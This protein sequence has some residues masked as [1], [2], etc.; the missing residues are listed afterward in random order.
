M[1]EHSPRHSY[2][3]AL[4]IGERYIFLVV[5]GFLAWR[6]V[7]AFQ[8]TASP[9]PLL[10]LLDQLVVLAFLLVRRRSTEM[11]LRPGDWII[12]FCGTLLPILVVAPSGE[13]LAPF[14]VVLGFMLSG[15]VIHVLAKLSLRRSF[16]I[17][18]ANRGVMSAGTYNFVRHPM[19]LGYMISHIGILLAGPNVLNLSA[20]LACWGFLILRIAAEE[21]VLTQD[22]AYRELCKRTRWRLIPW[23]Y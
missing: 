18:A 2:A 15:L 21:R 5:Y 13:P 22:A 12:G 4:D 20:I 14:P 8:A 16:G 9:I 1:P 10:Y 3:N 17:V 7:G 19:Y 11:S 23:V 6:M